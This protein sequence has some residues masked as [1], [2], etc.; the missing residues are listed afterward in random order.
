MTT[1]AHAHM[2]VNGTTRVPALL[3]SPA[4]ASTLAA[5]FWAGSFVVGRALRD[6]L[7]PV[8]LTFFRWLISLLVFAPF[9]W[10]EVA[11]HIQIVIREWRLIVGLAV[12]GITLFHPLVYIALQHT[13]ATNALLTFSLSPVV[14]LLGISLAGRKRPT[15]R[16]LTGVPLSLAGAAILITRG[17]VTVVTTMGANPG[18]VWMLGAVVVWAGYSMLLR[19]RPTDLPQTV[20]LVSSIAVALPML[21]PFTLLAASGNPLHLSATVLLG[22]LYVAVFGSVIGF[23]L[24]SHGVAELGPARA[25]QFVHLM[26]VFGAA[27]SFVFLGE[28]VSFA[29]ALGAG[30]V[31]SGIVLIETVKRS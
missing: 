13:T 12:T 19:R 4:L 25:G 23:L 22:T 8:V 18:D 10:R 26:P 7:D 6:D 9:A 5:L 15:M 31:L 30:L 24:W 29:Q 11:S 2:L 1:A 20:T 3:R 28:P 27:L 16:E 21:L 17:D 14:I